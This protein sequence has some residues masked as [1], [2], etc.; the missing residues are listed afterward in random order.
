[1]PLYFTPA[2]RLERA[3]CLMRDGD[4]QNALDELTALAPSVPESL[5]QAVVLNRGLAFYQ[6]RRYQDAIQVLEPLTSGS[7]KVAIPSLYHLSKTYRSLANAIDPTVYKTVIEKK[8]AGTVK[9][10]VGK[11]KKAK[12]VTRPRIVTTKKQIKLIDEAKKNQ[13][14]QYER[15]STERLNDLLQL[16]LSKTV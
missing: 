3:V 2:E 14:D 1:S 16:P 5:R 4:P 7:Y 15:L 8:N 12:T 10:R 9:V 6:L 11:G 13:K